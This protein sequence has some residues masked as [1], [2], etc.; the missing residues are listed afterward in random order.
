[1]FTAGERYVAANLTPG[2][3]PG[4]ERQKSQ[5]RPL[6]EVRIEVHTRPGLTPNGDPWVMRELAHGL[7]RPA[8][9]SG[10]QRRR[11]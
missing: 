7:A 5:I 10:A 8:G 11:A 9:R 3:D 2:K 1:M 6:R 4:G